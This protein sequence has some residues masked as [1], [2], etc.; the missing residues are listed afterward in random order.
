M[1]EQDPEAPP[2]V[3]QEEEAPEAPQA[4]P[5]PEQAP[6]P[7]WD[8]LVGGL[9]LAPHELA[10]K[11]LRDHGAPSLTTRPV[12]FSG[13][14]SPSTNAS[15]QALLLRQTSAIDP[16]YT[17]VVLQDRVAVLHD[18]KEMFELDPQDVF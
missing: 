7:T 6:G 10:Y 17:L 12:V 8:D 2:E 9:A 15:A 13:L 3:P 1:A 18:F 16:T 5:A 14:V 11:L 4:P